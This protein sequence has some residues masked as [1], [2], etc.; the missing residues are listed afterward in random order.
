MFHFIGK[1]GILALLKI[2]ISV[3]AFFRLMKRPLG[4][5]ARQFAGTLFKI[6][7]KRQRTARVCGI[8]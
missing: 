1:L 4:Y 7:L 5:T 3:K 6:L 8:I 2:S